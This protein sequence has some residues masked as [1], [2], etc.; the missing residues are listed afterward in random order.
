MPTAPRV[1]KRGIELPDCSPAVTQKIGPLSAVV[2]REMSDVDYLI[3]KCDGLFVA[4][5]WLNARP[6][7]LNGRLSGKSNALSARW[8]SVQ[9]AYFFGE[10]VILLSALGGR[11]I[12][13]TGG[14]AVSPKF[15]GLFD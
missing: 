8:A 9:T 14:A 3:I 12:G 2:P 10:P 11:C 13:S 15:D 7:E 6:E 4:V 5:L 1:T